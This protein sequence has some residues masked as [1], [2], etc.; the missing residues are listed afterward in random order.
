MRRVLCALGL[1]VS[2]GCLP[3][4]LTKDNAEFAQVPA[5]PFPSPPQA[6]VRAKANYAPASQEVAWRVDSV[7]RKLLTQDATSGL[8]G[9]QPMFATIGS[10]QP[11]I[12]H[13]DMNLV[14]V[15]E[16]LVKQ[17]KTE[18]QLAAVLASELGRMVVEREATARRE[19]RDPERQPPASLPIGGQ[20]HA[21]AADP[22]HLMELAEYEK[23]N[24]KAPRP[25]PRPDLR[26]VA[27]KL[28][29]QAGFPP[30]D[31]DAVQPLLQG[32]EQQDVLERQFKGMPM[33]GNWRP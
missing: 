18:G 6:T 9:F 14:Y 27:G 24:P 1:A 22:I 12:F 4:E 11:E 3:F 15:T 13:V 2:A 29:E 30:A 20:G 8:P 10:P 7:G 31:L 5:N 28:L 16:G 32:A 19:V 21:G 26:K 23:S 25:L 33:P 17:C